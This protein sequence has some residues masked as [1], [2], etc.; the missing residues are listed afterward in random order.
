MG[1]NCTPLVT[2][3]FCLVMREFTCCLFLYIKRNNSTTHGR[4]ILVN[5][6]SFSR[7][8]FLQNCLYVCPL[9]HWGEIGR[10]SQRF[11]LSEGT[12]IV[13]PL[14]PLTEWGT[15]LFA[16]RRVFGLGPVLKDDIR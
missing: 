12:E 10:R 1:T 4:E 8:F 9:R 13:C 2:D 11:L 14:E 3:M 6:Y 7:L 5:K 15:V 16:R